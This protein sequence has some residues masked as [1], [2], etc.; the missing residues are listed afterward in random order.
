M[1][2]GEGAVELAQGVGL[3]QRSS[4][5]GRR[6][7]RRRRPARSPRR[8]G[9]HL[10]HLG[11]VGCLAGVDPAVASS[12]A[13]VPATVASHISGNALLVPV[14]SGE[15]DV[16]AR[17]AAAARTVP[18]PP[19]ST[20]TAAPRPRMAATSERVSAA[21]PTSASS[22]TNSSSGHRP[23][24]ARRLSRARATPAATPMPSVETSTRST[25]TAPAAASSRSTMLVF[26]AFGNTDARATRRRMSRPDM[27]LATMPR[28]EPDTSG[29]AGAPLPFRS[30]CATVPPRPDRP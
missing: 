15:C 7:T 21:V 22:S 12:P 17:R 16:A 5:R 10:Q 3:P 20:I 19:R 24:D 26:S 11:A 4:R 28:V 30:S 25:P 9:C 29:N 2:F 14:D 8:P 18:S 23:S 13:A 27:G 6:S 1:R